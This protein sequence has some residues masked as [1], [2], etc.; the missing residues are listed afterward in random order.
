MKLILSPVAIHDLQSI[1]NYTLRTWGTEQEQLYLRDLWQKLET[2]R[3]HPEA[4]RIRTDL[5]LSCRSA[6]H[7]K[8]V[9]FFTVADDR[10]N[11]LRILHAAMDFSI[12]L[13]EDLE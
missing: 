10:V 12:H 3:H 4:W 8:H 5:D 6:R 13:L 7:G 1:S 9:I 2:I 11:V